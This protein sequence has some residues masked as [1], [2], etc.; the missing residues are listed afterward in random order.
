MSSFCEH[1]PQKEIIGIP[2][3]TCPHNSK[4]IGLYLAL[5]R[6]TFLVH[7]A[8]GQGLISIGGYWID[9][10]GSLTKGIDPLFVSRSRV[11]EFIHSM[12]SNEAYG[13]IW[14]QVGLSVVQP[15]VCHTACIIRQREDV[16]CTVYARVDRV[17]GSHREK[18]DLMK[19]K[20]SQHESLTKVC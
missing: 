8:G 19:S 20:G 10:P 9:T 17:R 1:K 11:E 13:I 18:P 6:Y 5:L 4:V 14:L 7:R 2:S 12:S 3:G 16:P 15:K